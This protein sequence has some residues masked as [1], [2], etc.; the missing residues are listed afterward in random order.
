MP[1][2]TSLTVASCDGLPP[3]SRSPF[4]AISSSSSPARVLRRCGP[5]RRPTCPRA[6][7]RPTPSRPSRG[8]PG[9]AAGARRLTRISAGMGTTERSRAPTAPRCRGDPGGWRRTRC[10]GRSGRA[11]PVNALPKIHSRR[12]SGFV[13]AHARRR[14]TT[15]AGT[16][17]R[18]LVFSTPRL[19]NCGAAQTG[20]DERVL[21]RIDDV[22]LDWFVAGVLRVVSNEQVS[23]RLDAGPDSASVRSGSRTSLSFVMRRN[24]WLRCGRP[25]RCSRSARPCLRYRRSS[26]WPQTWPQRVERTLVSVG[27]GDR[28]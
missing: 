1:I 8:T 11:S 23:E 4:R 26:C 25:P 16:I 28:I 12:I 10:R 13:A 20:I 24:S 15:S 21:P 14:S 7:P 5:R 2:S 3:V 6:S 17:C 9:R 18:P 27:R 22:V 19:D